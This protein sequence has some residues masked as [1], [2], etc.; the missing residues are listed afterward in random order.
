MNDLIKTM[1]ERDR[2]IQ[3]IE[4]KVR[5]VWHNEEWYIVINDV[6]QILTDSTN[7]KQYY[8][9]LKRRD[10]NLKE[11]MVKDEVFL[12]IN[13]DTGK[14]YMKCAN[15]EGIFLVM[16]QIPLPKAE[17]LAM[18]LWQVVRERV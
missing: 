13:C 16:M 11:R 3:L 5:R 18:W 4:Q 6:I 1:E 15:I 7:P 14:R 10:S 2:N 17:S 9:N 12:P 8:Y